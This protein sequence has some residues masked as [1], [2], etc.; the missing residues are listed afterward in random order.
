MEV[1]FA[2]LKEFAAENGYVLASYTREWVGENWILDQEIAQ[3][4]DE[5]F[6]CMVEQFGS[7]VDFKEAVTKD[8]LTVFRLHNN[9]NIPKVIPCFHIV[10]Q[11]KGISFR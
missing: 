4:D 7:G 6:V 2:E 9:F 11:D 3:Y 1:T 10:F 8:T 5:T